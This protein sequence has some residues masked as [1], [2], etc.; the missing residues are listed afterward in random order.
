M[1]ST[2]SFERILATSEDE[3]VR[4]LCADERLRKAARR[5]G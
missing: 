1:L 4:F 2:S 5:L 3:D